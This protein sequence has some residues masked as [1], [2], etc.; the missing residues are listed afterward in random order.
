MGR[1]TDGKKGGLMDEGV[2][3]G[4]CIDKWIREKSDGG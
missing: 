1:R 4:G 2:M 3:L